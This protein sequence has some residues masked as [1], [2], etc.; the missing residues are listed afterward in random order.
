M[1]PPTDPREERVYAALK[2]LQ[3]TYTRDTLASI[4][5][6]AARR[7]WTFL[8]FLDEVLVVAV[9]DVAAQPA[10]DDQLGS[11]QLSRR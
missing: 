7:Q 3:L 5:S 2:R 9:D 10:L 1:S 6:E 11:G 8:E 4:L